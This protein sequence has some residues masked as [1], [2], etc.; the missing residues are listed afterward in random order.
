MG[1]LALVKPM[2]LCILE[3]ARVAFVAESCLH[4]LS[5]KTVRAEFPGQF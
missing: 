1:Q 5:V 4:L 2:F 3:H